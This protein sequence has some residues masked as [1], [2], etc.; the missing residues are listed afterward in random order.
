MKQSLIRMTSHLAASTG[1]KTWCMYGKDRKQCQSS[2]LACVSD[3]L[4]TL[5]LW[6][7]LTQSFDT[8]DKVQSS[9]I[10]W[11]SVKKRK[12]LYSKVIEQFLV[13]GVQRKVFV[14]WSVKGSRRLAQSI[15]RQPTFGLMQSCLRS[16]YPSSKTFMPRFL[17]TKATL[18]FW[19]L[20]I[21]EGLT[22]RRSK[23]V[24]FC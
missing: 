20:V 18:S 7:M 23:D 21:I 10:G 5:I 17:C 13:K 24:R 8:F 22:Q 6:T 16:H 14:P 2:K 3:V 15:R 4:F 12:Q 19:D 9:V 1:S 11:S